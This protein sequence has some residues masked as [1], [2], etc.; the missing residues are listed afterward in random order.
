MTDRRTDEWRRKQ[1]PIVFF[2]LLFFLKRA[3]NNNG[4][5]RM[6]VELAWRIPR[7]IDCS[8]CDEGVQLL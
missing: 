3:D 1:Y 5:K 8:F 2:Y 7:Q 4:N 6:S